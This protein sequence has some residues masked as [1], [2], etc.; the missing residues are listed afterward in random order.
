MSTAC[1]ATSH[2][3][4]AAMTARNQAALKTLVEEHGVQLRAFPAEVLAALRAAAETLV[5]EAAA[6]DAFSARVVASYRA[7]RAQVFETTRISEQAFLDARQ[8]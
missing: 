6:A 3:L 1:A 2:T 7:F 8:G 4:L 5:E